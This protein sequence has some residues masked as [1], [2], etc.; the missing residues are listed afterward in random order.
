MARPGHQPPEA[1]AAQHVANAALG[2]PDMRLDRTQTVCPA[3]A[4]HPVPREVRALDN[5]PGDCLLWF[6][7]QQARRAAAR[8]VMQAGQAVRIGPFPTV[9]S[10][11]AILAR[12]PD[13]AH[14]RRMKVTPALVY[15]ATA[16]SMMVSAARSQSISALI[17]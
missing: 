9:V 13:R 5:P 16:D 6:R 17:P 7:R 3:P 15:S 4:R 10:L 1:K 12:S 2:H 8:P 11:A 14:K